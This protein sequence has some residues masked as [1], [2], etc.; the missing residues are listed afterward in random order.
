VKKQHGG[1]VKI[2]MYIETSIHCSY[3]SFSCTYCL[4]HLVPKNYWYKWCMIMS[5]VLFHK[6]SYFFK[7]MVWIHNICRVIISEK[8]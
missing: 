6:V 7:F 1:H 4:F 3:A 5:D 8:K 2:F